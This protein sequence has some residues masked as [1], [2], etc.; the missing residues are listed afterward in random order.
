MSTTNKR[1]PYLGFRFRV[2]VDSLVVAG[3]SEVTG[4]ELGMQPEEYEEGGVNTHTHRLP[5]RYTQPNVVLRRGLTD[6]R[7]LW[8][9]IENA[10]NGRIERRNGR[11]ILLDSTGE[12][13]WGWSFRDAYPVRWAGPELRADQGA[14]AIETLE[15]AH[16]GVTKMNGLPGGAASTG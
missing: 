2:E 8:D 5:T 12:L 1:D 16:E 6:S 3:F 4:L 9:W 13:S 7:E 14:V 11:V 10:V 15:L